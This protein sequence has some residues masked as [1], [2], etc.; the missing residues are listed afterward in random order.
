MSR[1][2]RRRRAGRV[3]TKTGRSALLVATRPRA[4]DHADRPT[5]LA[6]KG[7]IP[8]HH[9]DPQFRGHDRRRSVRSDQTVCPICGTGY[10]WRASPPKREMR[11]RTSPKMPRGGVLCGIGPRA[12]LLPPEKSPCRRGRRVGSRQGQLLAHAH[13]L[14]DSHARVSTGG[15]TRLRVQGKPGPRHLSRGL[16]AE[17]RQTNDPAARD[18]ARCARLIHNFLRMTSSARGPA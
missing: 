10:P 2:P 9:R 18:L 16:I 1:C 15:D 7:G 17:D 6:K 5:R 11:A 8:P 4:T 14:H 13:A 12:R 3:R